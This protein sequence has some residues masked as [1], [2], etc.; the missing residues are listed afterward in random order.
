MLND[1]HAP[2]HVREEDIMWI[3]KVPDIEH[4][5]YEVRY[6]SKYIEEEL[7]FKVGLS[8]HAGRFE[9]RM[10]KKSSKVPELPVPVSKV[11]PKRQVGG[12]DPQSLKKKKLEGVT[13]SADKALPPPDLEAELTHSLNEW[14]NEF[15]K[16]KY[17]QGEYKRKYDLR[18]KEVKMLEEELI[19][20][21]TKL[22]N[23]VHSM[24]LQNQQIDRL[25]MDFE[26][27]QAVITQ[28]RKDQKASVEK[29]GGLMNAFMF[30]EFNTRRLCTWLHRH[31]W[32]DGSL[33]LELLS[34][35]AWVRIFSETHTLLAEKE[36]ALSDLESSRIIED[37]KKYISFKTIIQDH[38]QEARDHIYDVEVKA[39]EQQCIGEGFIWGFLKGV[40]LMQRK[41]GVTV[42]GLTPSQ[43]SGDPSSDPDGDEIES[44]LQK[45]FAL[46]SSRFSQELKDLILRFL[47]LSDTIFYGWAQ[48]PF[49]SSVLPPM[50]KR[51]RRAS[52][53]CPAERRALGGGPTESR[54]SN[55]DLAERR[56]SSGGPAERRASGGGPAERRATGGGP[57]ERRDFRWW[58]G[59]TSG[60]QVVVRQNVGPR[61]VVRQNVGPSGGGPAVVRQNSDGGR[62]GA[63]GQER[64]PISLLIPSS[65][66]PF[67]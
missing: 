66:G 62:G 30:G 27:A 14:N 50:M 29:I 10:L 11:A 2:L 9:A 55:G 54:A 35:H 43:A 51:E 15:V 32:V 4:L 46:E 1:L 57:A 8:F 64:S 41:T 20:C 47:H 36:A 6:L 42:E 24:S 7:L 16:V 63:K 18:T 49:F 26:G 65:L 25:Q 33:A 12:G 40:R 58:S 3:L 13:T 67:S 45:A 48:C 23:I 39:L 38:V 52:S 60:L 5:L 37:F 61:V 56:A 17:L 21:R 31:A 44:K 59:R 22:A 28:L 19:E 34:G 53:G